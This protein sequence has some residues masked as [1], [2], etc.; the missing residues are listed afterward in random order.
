MFDSP[1]DSQVRRFIMRIATTDGAAHQMILPEHFVIPDEHSV[2]LTVT[3]HAREDTADDH[4]HG[5]YKRMAVLER[6]GGIVALVG[7]KMIGTDIEDAILWDV[8]VTVDTANKCPAI[9]VT[10]ASATNIRWVALIEAVQI[11]YSD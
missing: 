11:G 5:M 8:E 10:G 9:T 2:A 6:T 7:E 3:V 4:D 1:G